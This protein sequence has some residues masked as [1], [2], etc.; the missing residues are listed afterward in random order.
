MRLSR[1]ETVP[2]PLIPCSVRILVRA[3]RV[4]II[5][6]QKL[7]QRIQRR[8]ATR[9]HI[10]RMAKQY[11]EEGYSFAEIEKEIAELKSDL[12]KVERSK[13]HRGSSRQEPEPDPAVIGVDPIEAVPPSIAASAPF[14]GGTQRPAVWEWRNQVENNW[15]PYS[16]D[17][18][19]KM[20]DKFQLH[21]RHVD[22][23]PQGAYCDLKNL[24][25]AQWDG[26]SEKVA[27]RR[28]P[29]A[30]SGNSADI[31]TFDSRSKLIQAEAV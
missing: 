21:E 7:R 3:S 28:V 23:E 26:P 24:Y 31:L 20:E 1:Y 18:S 29:A 16:K 10:Q 4:I 8:E 15:T 11:P 2:Q 25:Q 27:I 22:V 6:A 12:T 13:G 17:V 5:Q 30:E 14:L 19:A 9:E